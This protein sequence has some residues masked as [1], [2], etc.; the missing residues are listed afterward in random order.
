MQHACNA[1]LFV[2]VGKNHT[3]DV[4]KGM[5]LH[6]A[7]VLPSKPNKINYEPKVPGVPPH[8]R[9]QVQ[10]LLVG[11]DPG[12]VICRKVAKGVP[13]CVLAVSSKPFCERKIPSVPWLSVAS[14]KMMSDSHMIATGTVLAIIILPHERAARYPSVL[15]PVSRVG[16]KNAIFRYMGSSGNVQEKCKHQQMS[17]HKGLSRLRRNVIHR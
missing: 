8:M 6:I 7:H 14:A 5:Y 16:R 15:F 2:S 13:C 4:Y 11:H 3:K 12:H 1:C 9:A 10:F 17:A